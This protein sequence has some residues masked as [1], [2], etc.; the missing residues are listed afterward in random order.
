[1]DPSRM[2]RYRASE[3]SRRQHLSRAV[4]VAGTA[5]IALMG[6]AVPAHADSIG[7]PDPISVEHTVITGTCVPSRDT[8]FVRSE[9]LNP[10]K[11]VTG[12]EY[13]GNLDYSGGEG[14]NTVDYWKAY[15]WSRGDRYLECR[16][17]VFVYAIY[18][19]QPVTGCYDEAYFLGLPDGGGFTG[20]WQR[21]HVSGSG[22][23]PL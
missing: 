11:Y 18:G 20:S 6:T 10:Q 23:C 8:A 22:P 12:W 1:M 4:L 5:T 21:G 13:R 19:T 14:V 16:G 17:D 3:G 7:P 2:L 9:Q 15:S